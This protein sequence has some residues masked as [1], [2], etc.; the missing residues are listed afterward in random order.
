MISMYMFRIGKCVFEI[1]RESHPILGGGIHFVMRGFLIP[2]GL[3]AGI[4]VLRIG[5]RQNAA[6]D[7]RV[8]WGTLRH[9]VESLR[10]WEWCG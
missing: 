9:F 1:V 2:V 3:F 8:A 10:L 4:V 5:V 7:L 6:Y